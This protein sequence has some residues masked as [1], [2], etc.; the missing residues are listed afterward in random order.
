M[1]WFPKVAKQRKEA[2]RYE[3][4]KDPTDLMADWVVGFG[5]MMWAVFLVTVLRYYLALPRAFHRDS[6]PTNNRQTAVVSAS[7]NSRLFASR[8][9]EQV[10]KTFLHDSTEGSCIRPKT[11]CACAA[12]YH[13]KTCHLKPRNRSTTYLSPIQIASD[14]WDSF[15]TIYVPRVFR[16][17]LQMFVSLP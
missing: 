8:L 11:T 17:W 13:T 12:L 9:F 16:D 3:S 2:K 5:Y 1:Q 7:G 14:A 6:K 4:Q 15:P 10:E